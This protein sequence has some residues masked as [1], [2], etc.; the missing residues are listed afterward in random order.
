MPFQEFS[1]RFP[2]LC[3][4]LERAKVSGRTGQAYLLAG[5]DLPT[6]ER[7]ALAWAQTAACLD[8]DQTGKACGKC[9]ICRAFQHQAYPELLRLAPES[10]SRIIT[11]EAMREFD[12]QLNLSAAPD[13]LKI[14]IISE[15]ESLGDEAQNAFL[16]TLEEP[17]PRTMLLLLTVN[18]RKLLPTIRSRCQRL[19]LL[20]NSQEYPEAEK[21][22]LF[23]ILSTVRSQAGVKAALDAS[24]SLQKI[25]KGL[26]G[27]AEAFVADNWDARW[28]TSAEGNRSL[29]KQ[30]EDMKAVR[31]EAEY[32]RLRAQI[33][34][35]MQ[36]WFQA[37]LLQSSGASL[38]YLPTGMNKYLQ[39]MQK[40][41]V[42][43]EDADFACRQI[44][45]YASCLKANVDEN[46]ALTASLLLICEKR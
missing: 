7:F 37:V 19:L 29:T 35:A 31:I 30:L 14:G 9:R 6:L 42:S 26:R 38:N 1:D 45:D 8:P 5:D 4:S 15:A 2:A 41:N 20:Q 3:R 32:V 16:K 43:V 10:K 17:P 23:E 28:E 36:A 24:S 12:Q 33:V 22:G 39:E 27:E 25:L 40:Y 21:S 44:E 46:L 18:P 11:I 34:T 13:H